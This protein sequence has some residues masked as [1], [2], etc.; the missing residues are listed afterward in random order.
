METPPEGPGL[1]SRLADSLVVA[2]LV[3][4]ALAVEFAGLL[5]ASASQRETIHRVALALLCFVA[6]YLWILAR[7]SARSVGRIR[8]L[9]DDVLFGPGTKRDREAVDILVEAL[10]TPDDRARTT[11]LRTLRKISGLDLGEDPGPWETWWSA[12]RPTFTR[13]GP[14]KK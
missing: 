12:A 8:P 3:A 7:R 1:A 10:R 4:T 9:L 11:A 13:P 2:A 6:A 5:G 14:P